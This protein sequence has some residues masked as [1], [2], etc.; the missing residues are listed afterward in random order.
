MTSRRVWKAVAMGVLVALVA[1]DAAAWG[2][3][4]ER[5]IAKTALELLSR[6]HRGGHFKTTTWEYEDD[7][8][9][10][11]LDGSA[12]DL[13]PDTA[14]EKDVFNLIQTEIQ[15]LRGAREHGVGSYHSYRMGRLGTLVSKLYLPYSLGLEQV[16]QAHELKQQIA[17]D[18]DAHVKDFTFRPPQASLFYI[19]DPSN[20]FERTR[21]LRDY[22]TAI[23][24]D[25]YKRGT[26]YRGYLANGALV[27]YRQAVQGVADTWH[28]VI[29]PKDEPTDVA[30]SDEALTWY[31]TE[32]I[33]YLLMVRKNRLEANQAYERFASVNPGILA[34]YDKV[35]DCFYAF[36]DSRRAAEE[37][38]NALQMSGPERQGIVKKLSRHYIEEG[39]RHLAEEAK[40]PE[41]PPLALE[42]ALHAFRMALTVDQTSDE[43]ASLLAVTQVAVKEK[44]DRQTFAMELVATADKVMIEASR[45]ADGG[46]YKEALSLYER[47]VVVTDGVD[48]E[49]PDIRSDARTIADNAD[50][51]IQK[52]M[53]TVIDEAE[54]MID[55]GQVRVDDNMFD[56]ARQ[57]YEQVEQILSV[58]PDDGD[59]STNKQD[60]IERAK[61]KMEEAEV[62]R[63]R[64]EED[65]KNLSNAA[66]AAGGGGAAAPAASGGGAR[67]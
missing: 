8:L 39:Q 5:A 7:V 59:F 60:L 48:D 11:A 10:G 67:D 43:A 52:I 24:A 14:T 58:I 12:T 36:G 32:E 54:A 18:I 56:E 33:E 61:E 62:A 47:A 27:F 1:F 65:Q 53:N 49:F 15:L 35:G 40:G 6:E 44:K 38:T 17:K 21:E 41:G 4:T 45:A 29:S 34:A 31:L 37:W 25:D 3:K 16:P 28:T 66:A 19:R 26:G 22:A 30:P 51:A 42:D 57:A 55:E 23:I 46:L 2:P 20:Y 64:W 13:V 63:R 50:N 9:R